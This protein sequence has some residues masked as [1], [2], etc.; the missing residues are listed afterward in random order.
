[1]VQRHRP[2]AHQAVLDH[3]RVRLVHV[4]CVALPVDV[5]LCVCL[6]VPSYEQ[7]YD[8][9]QNLSLPV[10]RCPACRTHA[11]NMLP[12]S[13]WAHKPDCVLNSILCKYNDEVLGNLH[14][15][16]QAI[17]GAEA[18]EAASKGGTAGRGAVSARGG[19]ATAG[20]SLFPDAGGA[21]A[22]TGNSGFLRPL[23]TDS[24]ASS[25]LPPQP[26]GTLLRQTSL[27]ELMSFMTNGG[28]DAKYPSGELFCVVGVAWLLLAC[29]VAPLRC[30]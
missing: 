3:H 18:Y 4:R 12:Q 5:Y 6:C 9:T 23:S 21:S 2:G 11:D 28:G 20:E 7:N 27:D 29:H 25:G 24:D 1:M 14:T 22:G 17:H 26:A 19:G 13:E 30:F 16:V 10:R 15:L 8:G